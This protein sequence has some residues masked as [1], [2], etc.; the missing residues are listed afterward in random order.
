MA[1]V[2]THSELM[3]EAK[4][5]ADA[6]IYQYDTLSPKLRQQCL[7]LI[8]DQLGSF[9][10]YGNS[11]YDAIVKSLRRAKG[12][13]YLYGRGDH[14]SGEEFEHYV[15][16]AD[17]ADALDAI[18]LALRAVRY[19]ANDATSTAKSRQ[20]AAEALEDFNYDCRVAGFGY[21][22]ID[23]DL[24]RVDS[25][26]MHSEVVV[27]A[28]QVL[29]D[30][31]YRHADAEFRKAH[32]HWRHGRKSEAL[33]DCLKAFESTMKVIADKRGWDPDPKANAKDLVQLMYD[34]G[35]IPPYYSTHFAGLRSLLESGIPTPRNRA[36]GHG[37]G[38]APTPIPDEL[39]AYV[40]HQTAA[41][42]VF[43]A[44]AE[45]SLP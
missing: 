21:Q 43:L 10:D 11:V 4:G 20:R 37:A 30:A 18:E 1:R 40:L 12:L 19:Q 31:R 39:V 27:P 26:M 5:K 23:G 9:D 8:A 41:T 25:E 36:G 14:L 16:S 29:A 17:D 32:E 2:K 3:K 13:R 7:H 33:V 34:K 44:A 45:K 22:L 6:E 28:L 38:V 15:R 42:I 35:L 24:V